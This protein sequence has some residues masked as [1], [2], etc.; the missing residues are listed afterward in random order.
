MIPS[1]N[2]MAR[3]TSDIKSIDVGKSIVTLSVALKLNFVWF[4]PRIETWNIGKSS[5]FTSGSE[6]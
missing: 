1:P 6:Y 2:N 4:D 5:E 3:Q